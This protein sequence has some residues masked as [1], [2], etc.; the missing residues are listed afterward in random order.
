MDFVSWQPISGAE[1]VDA[2]QRFVLETLEPLELGLFSRPANQEITHY[3]GHRGI[4]FGRLDAGTAMGVV[5]DGDC[6][7]FHVHSLT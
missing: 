3:G 5:V 2:V 4:A 1:R 7:I 6:D